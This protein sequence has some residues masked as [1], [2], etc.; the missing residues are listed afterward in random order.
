MQ[1]ISKTIESLCKIYLKQPINMMNLES[2]RMKYGIS[3]YDYPHNYVCVWCPSS[4]I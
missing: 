2:E 3:L 4:N 1:N